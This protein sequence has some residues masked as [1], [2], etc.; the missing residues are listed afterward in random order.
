MS[1]GKINVIWFLAWALRVI[2]SL[3]PLVRL[4]NVLV[5]L[6]ALRVGKGALVLHGLAHENLLDGDLNL[7]KK[8][9]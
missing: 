6:K 7:T 4:R 3:L 5:E 8:G 1:H 9:L 2:F